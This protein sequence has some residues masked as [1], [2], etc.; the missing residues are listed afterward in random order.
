MIT[1][2]LENPAQREPKEIT[3]ALTQKS[4]AKLYELYFPLV[5]RICNRYTKNYELAQDLTQEVF[6]KI[7]DRME[8]FQGQSQPS[9]WLYRIT[10]NH[11]L[12]YLRW[13]KR[14]DELFLHYSR[15]TEDFQSAELSSDHPIKRLLQHLLE[16]MD[17]RSRQVIFLR[18]EVGLTHREISEIS[19]ISR[20]AITRRISRFNIMVSKIKT[21]LSESMKLIYSTNEYQRNSF[22]DC[23]EE[24]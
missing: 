16:D 17:E 8:S 10:V 19:G 5:Q 24:S 6:L 7:H 12:D 4:F 18:Y 21:E 13:K 20:V 14:N 1:T 2:L 11:C 22:E 15:S 3:S 23:T 9:T